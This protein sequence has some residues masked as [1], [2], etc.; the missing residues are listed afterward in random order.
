MLTLRVP[1]MLLLLLAVPGAAAEAVASTWA[2]IDAASV[3]V[4]GNGAVTFDARLIKE[5]IELELHKVGLTCIDSQ[6]TSPGLPRATIVA[7]VDGMR[8][9]TLDG[10][11]AGWIYH[12]SLSA[13]C[14]AR[15]VA[16]GGGMVI[17]AEHHGIGFGPANDLPD[18]CIGDFS[19]LASRMAMDWL[20]DNPQ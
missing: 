11:P 6:Q 2:G 20:G 14:W 7:H 9:Q 12:W 18:H 15:Q 3:V 16:D 4:V 8:M 17:L 1:L 5:R 13:S 19:T 10:A